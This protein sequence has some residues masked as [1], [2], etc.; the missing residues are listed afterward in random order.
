MNK[1]KLT[2]FLGEFHAGFVNR[3]IHIVGLVL[4]I[5]GVMER[6]FLV[7]FI[8]PIIMEMGHLYN[9]LLLKNPLRHFNLFSLLG[10]Q[11]IAYILLALVVTLLLKLGGR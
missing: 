2:Y 5:W 6:N 3:L 1:S 10:V 8:A 9:H 7:I 4:L 11:T